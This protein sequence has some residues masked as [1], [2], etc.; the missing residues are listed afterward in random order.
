LP[1]LTDDQLVKVERALAKGPT[2]NGFATELWTLARVATVIEQVTGVS[3]STTQ[4]WSILRERLG[5]SRQR[6]SRRTLEADPDP[7]AA[8]G[9]TLIVTG[10]RG[11]THNG[12]GRSL[13][14]ELPET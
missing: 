8:P 9:V 13:T 5:W 4:T 10:H 7:S 14:I 2:H 3:Y 1:R 6:P 11:P 12:L